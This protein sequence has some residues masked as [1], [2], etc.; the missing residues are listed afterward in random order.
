MSEINFIMPYCCIAGKYC[1][2]NAGFQ[3]GYILGLVTIFVLLS[4]LECT[5]QWINICRGPDTNVESDN[6]G[7]NEED[8]NK[9][10]EQKKDD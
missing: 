10:D 9:T 5:N 7:D 1:S 6:E 3:E 2:Y 8:N 4:I